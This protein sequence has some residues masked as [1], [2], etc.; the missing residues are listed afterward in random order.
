MT[1]NELKKTCLAYAVAA[2]ALW[3]VFILLLGAISASLNA[4]PYGEVF[5]LDGENGRLYFM[6][7]MIF[8][9]SCWF[10][11]GY[12]SRRKYLIEKDFFRKQSP[13]LTDEEFSRVFKAHYLAS[14]FKVLAIVAFTA[15]PWYCIGYVR[16]KLTT[17]DMVVLSLILTSAVI[18][19]GVYYKNRS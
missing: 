14:R 13:S 15:I 2:V 7:F 8:W 10:A 3:I 1:K 17:H 19:L 12:Y 16:D 5:T 9:T 11:I 6:L 4:I 18:C